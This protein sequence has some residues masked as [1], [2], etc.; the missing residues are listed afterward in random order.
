MIKDEKNVKTAEEKT[1]KDVNVEEDSEK[2]TD[3]QMEKVAAGL[4]ELVT[5]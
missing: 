4:N 5:L 3:E 1:K 2:L